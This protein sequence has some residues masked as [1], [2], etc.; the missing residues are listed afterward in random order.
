MRVKIK[1]CLR[2]SL[3]AEVNRGIV[4]EENTPPR[5]NAAVGVLFLQVFSFLW[6]ILLV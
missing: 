4:I 6:Y 2:V 1:K 5:G 3:G